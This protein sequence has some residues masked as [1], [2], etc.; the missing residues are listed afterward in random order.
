MSE[1]PPILISVEQLRPG[2]YISLEGRWIDH[3][4]IFNH[5]KISGDKQIETLKQLGIRSVLYYPEKSNEEPLP[6]P[7]E[8]EEPVAAPAYTPE[9]LA[10]MEEKRKGIERLN[11]QKKKIAECE[12]HYSESAATFKNIMK[13][14]FSR[15]Q[16]AGQQAKYLVHSVVDSFMT[17][18]DVVIQLMGD[19][20]H[21]ENVY[22]HSLNVLILSMVL[23]KR[24]NLTMEQ[25]R[26]IGMGALFHDIGK[27]RVPDAILKKKEPLNK[28]EL[29]FYRLH[30]DYG[31]A[32]AKELG[33]FP[34]EAIDVIAQHH[35]YLDGSGY[36]R[37]IEGRE[38]TLP[39]RIVTITNT[40]DNLCNPVKL[41]NALTPYEAMAHMY[42]REQKHHL[43]DEKALKLFVSCL[44]VYPPG[45]LV[46]LSNDMLGMAI[47]VNQNNL[48]KPSVLVYDKAVPK[49]E[50]IIIDLADI[51]ELSIK[52]C[53]HP[54]HLAP[55]IYDYLSPRKNVRYFFQSEKT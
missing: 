8:P 48:L 52:R 19:R 18:S 42:A 9:Q 26:A 54:Q 46:E 31:L 29:S 15:P 30:V 40:Y 44:G 55:E 21:D 7:A 1:S 22:Y 14:F 3:P 12:K 4:F 51:P 16:E 2:V 36:P 49:N 10:L 33:I 32:M 27:A 24:M 34:R 6:P 20:V 47:S 50:A 5:F 13:N 53:I 45:S 11:E 41:E 23:A 25:M 28:H 17:D 38:I 39:A 37:G 35:E 43:F